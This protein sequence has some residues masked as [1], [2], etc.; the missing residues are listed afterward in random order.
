[1]KKRYN[2]ANYSWTSKTAMNESEQWAS[3]RRLFA[4]LLM[5]LARLK[6]RLKASSLE[7]QARGSGVLPL[8]IDI[9]RIESGQQRG[10][11]AVDGRRIWV[12]ID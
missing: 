6:D 2:S 11:W 7:H 3:L 12:F 5:H 4:R 10:S 1:M 8:A 9:A